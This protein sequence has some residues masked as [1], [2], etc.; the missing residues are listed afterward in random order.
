MSLPLTVRGQVTIST[1]ANGRAGAIF[2]PGFKYG[3]STAIGFNAVGHTDEAQYDDLVNWSSTSSIEAVT[4]QYRLVSGGITATSIASAM[5][6]QGFIF[7]QEFSGVEATSL[8]YVNYTS[9]LCLSSVRQTMKS[10][11]PMFFRFT[12]QGPES[13]QFQTPNGSTAGD[14]TSVST[15]DWT[16]CQITVQGGE[17]SKPAIVLDYILNFELTFDASSSYNLFAT[18]ARG[19]DAS[20]IKASSRIAATKPAWYVGFLES[21]RKEI[22]SEAVKHAKAAIPGL[23]A[24][25]GTA[26]GGPV[27]AIVGGAAGGLLKDHILEV[28]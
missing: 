7:G 19:S 9:Q 4:S 10:S 12:P 6:S 1:D 15:N 20:I 25:G 22:E 23:F 3:Y 13:R 17:P 8:E 2:V 28:D 14:I 5:T 21:L 11:K 18:R 16:W 27:G 26:I 24:A